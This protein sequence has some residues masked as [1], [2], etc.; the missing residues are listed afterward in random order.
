MG[1]YGAGWG[2]RGGGWCLYVRAFAISL[3]GLLAFRFFGSESASPTGAK[4]KANMGRH[5]NKVSE[6]NLPYSR[7][8]LV[9]ATPSQPLPQG[10]EPLPPRSAP[11]FLFV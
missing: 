10:S 2:G 3:S 1:G 11:L 8:Q 6:H 5:R 9:S 7:V 4:K